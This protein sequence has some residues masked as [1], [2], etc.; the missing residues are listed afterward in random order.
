MSSNISLTPELE[1]Y[2]RKQVESGLYS[3]ISEF[4]RDAVRTHQNLENKL[5]LS[6]MHLELAKAGKDVDQ[7]KISPLK[8]KDIL[9]ESLN[10]N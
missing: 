5:Y 1:L 9:E 10:D 7:N 8:M 2:A 6:E 4:I 3:S